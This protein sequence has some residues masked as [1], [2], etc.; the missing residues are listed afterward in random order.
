MTLVKK[1]GLTLMRYLSLSLAIA[2][3]PIVGA[4]AAL[5]FSVSLE[6]E[7][8]GQQASTSG[9]D[10]VG[11]ENFD[12]RASGNGQN[13]S[14]N[15][16][17]S[18]VFS[19]VYKNVQVLGADQY[20]GAYGAGKYA[21]TFDNPGYT[22]DLTTTRPGGVTYFGFW[23]SALDAS[24]SVSFYQGNS[25][26]FTFNASDAA[27]FIN[28][29]PNRDSYRCNS[30]APFVGQNCGEPYVFLNFY[31]EAGTTFDRVAF[32]QVGGGGYESDNH[33][34]GIWNTKSGTI[35]PN[36]GV[37][38]E[39]ESWA[40]MIAGFSMIGVSMRRRSRTVAA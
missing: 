37:V 1:K 18:G 23:L 26:L 24:N 5:P 14:T 9:F 22:L 10:F 39:P 28:S 40:L 3:L 36:A 7:A 29:L 32:N 11:V 25:M 33:T 34:V 6:S 2:M 27:N 16:G 4:Q 30:N 8:P 38:P 21:V 15:F 13:F 31:A 35:I 17:S 12:A 20:G 19:G